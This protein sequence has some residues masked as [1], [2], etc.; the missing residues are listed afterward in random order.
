MTVSPEKNKKTKLWFLSEQKKTVSRNSEKVGKNHDNT[1][2]VT[3][4]LL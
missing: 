4:N 3:D 2:P 1:S